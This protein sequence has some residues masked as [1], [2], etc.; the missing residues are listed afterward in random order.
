MNRISVFS[1]WAKANRQFV[2]QSPIHE[3]VKEYG[4]R[5]SRSGAYSACL[6][7]GLRGKR[8]NST[9]YAKF[10]ASLNW[11]LPD[12][13]LSKVWRT[14]RG[15]LRA[16]RKRLCLPHPAWRLHHDRNCPEFLAA[17]GKELERSRR[18]NEKRP[19]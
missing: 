3:V 7:L 2:M 8:I 1:K 10:W 15:N 13:I 5:A 16:R 12:T 19:A 6:R 17:L 4:R 18:F 14:N 9:R 11:N